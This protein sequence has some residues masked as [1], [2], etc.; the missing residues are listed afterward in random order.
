MRSVTQ[1]KYVINNTR[2]WQ[3]DKDLGYSFATTFTED[4]TRDMSGVGHFTPMFTVEQ[5]SY[6]AKHIPVDEA[7]KILQMIAGGQPFT[8]YYFSPYYGTWRSD[9]FYVGQGD[10]TIGTL[11]EDREKLSQLSFKM[12]GINPI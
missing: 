10:I 3:P 5:S 4:S 8:L 7:A 6:T 12:T 1:N 2:I 9:Q 11:E